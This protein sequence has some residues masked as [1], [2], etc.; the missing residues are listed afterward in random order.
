[1]SRP[2]SCSA[3]QPLRQRQVH[4]HPQYSTET[5]SAHISSHLSLAH[6]GP[7]LLHYLKLE[8]NYISSVCNEQ[9]F[10]ANAFTT[11]NLIRDVLRHNIYM[12]AASTKYP[13]SRKQAAWRARAAQP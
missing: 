9:K 7:A 6:P 12:E 4:P 11:I 5:H 10:T 8:N 13:N 1:M 3:K 2:C